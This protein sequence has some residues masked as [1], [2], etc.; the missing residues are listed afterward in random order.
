MDKALPVGR[1]LFI[2]KKTII[3]KYVRINI[4]V[5]VSNLIVKMKNL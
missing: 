3:K 4:F 1:A 2:L 5:N